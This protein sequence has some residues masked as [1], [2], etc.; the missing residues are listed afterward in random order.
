MHYVQTSSRKILWSMKSELGV[1]SFSTGLIP[2]YRFKILM[3]GGRTLDPDSCIVLLLTSESSIW[4]VGVLFISR[5]YTVYVI[6]QF[7]W[8]FSCSQ[9]NKY[10]I[11]SVILNFLNSFYTPYQFSFG[12]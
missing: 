7:V 4:L 12:W 8:N 11:V 9:Q 3:L 10:F 2:V 6:S 1:K 5:I